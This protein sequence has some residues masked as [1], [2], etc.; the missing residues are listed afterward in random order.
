MYPDNN[1][2]FEFVFG[3]KPTGQF[4]VVE[5]PVTL[6]FRCHSQEDFARVINY[7]LTPSEDSKLNISEVG[8]MTFPD[9]PNGTSWDLAHRV[10]AVSDQAEA[11]NSAVEDYMAH[12]EQHAINN[13]FKY[14]GTRPKFYHWENMQDIATLSP[15]MQKDKVVNYLRTNRESIDNNR[16]HDEILAQYRGLTI[17]DEQ[18]MQ[19]TVDMLNGPYRE[20]FYG[21]RIPNLER[22]LN[23]MGVNT[24]VTKA[25]IKQV[26]EDELPNTTRDALN[27]LRELEQN[28]FSKDEAINLL[29]NETLVKWPKTVK[30]MIEFRKK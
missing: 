16:L 14:A 6:G 13:L 26:F 25:A 5:G 11:G 12:E 4:E 7:G 22:E 8:G 21:D 10:I 30:R 24:E 1:Q 9:P 15:E 23:R 3:F 20:H 27:S 18:D 28:G 29:Q 17:R 19:T 2:L